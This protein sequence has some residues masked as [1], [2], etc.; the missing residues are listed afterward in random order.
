MY[1][2]HRSALQHTSSAFRPSTKSRHSQHFCSAFYTIEAFV[3]L[4]LIIA[5][6]VITYK[7]YSDRHVFLHIEAA[8]DKLLSTCC[9]SSTALLGVFHPDIMMSSGF[10][11]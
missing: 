7:Y 3:N 1:L 4:F 8:L 11:H 2:S 6:L 5:Y 9:I 10:T